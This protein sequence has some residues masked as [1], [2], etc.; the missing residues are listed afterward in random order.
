VKILQIYNESRARIGGDM[1]VVDAT[2]RILAQNGHESRLLMKSSRVLDDSLFRRINAFWGGVY[3]ILTFREMRRLIEKDRPDVVHVH[4]V[5]PMFSPSVLVACRRA[6][7]PVV[8][9]VHDH[10]MTCPTA[11]H[12]Y[13]GRVCEECIG[14]HEYRC[15]LKN[16]RNNILE[17]SAYALRSAVARHFRLFHDNVSV[18]MV[19]TPFGKEKLLQAGFR[20]DQIVIAPNPVSRRDAA[21]SPRKGKYVAFAGRVNPEKGVDVFLAA[22]ARMPDIPFKV[23]GDGTVWAEMRARATHNVEFLGRLGFNDLLAFYRLSRVL[24]VPSLC[25][26][27]F[28]MVAVDAMSLGV[29]VIAS[30]IGGLPYLVDDGI[31]GSLFEPGNPEDLAMHV[32]RLWE[33]DQLCYRMGK[34]ARQKV[35]REYSEDAYFH[36]LMAVYQTA[37]RLSVNVAPI[38][39]LV[40]INDTV[41]IREKS[42]NVDGSL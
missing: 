40:Q 23:A 20:E 6:G 31:T 2:M 22:A 27:Q 11:F 3:N 1:V 8:M 41:S 39:S 42:I 9:T 26:E 34:A 4:N 32:R 15:V 38:S 28:G 25:F 14:G 19:M 16:C 12:L 33:D 29:P 36:T 21:S 18:L 24:V 35:M 5:Y 30:R 10:K 37:I 7:V 17:S 13:R